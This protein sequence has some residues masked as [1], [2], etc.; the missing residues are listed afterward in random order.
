MARKISKKEL[1]AAMPLPA[2]EKLKRTDIE[3]KIDPVPV[4]SGD[5][6]KKLR[7]DLNLG[8]GAL[9]VLLNVQPSVIKA[10]ERGAKNPDGPCCKLLSILEKKGIESL[11]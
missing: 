11:L 4:Y 7:K 8:T 2:A 5:H 3:Q 6:V 1:P 10:W 9:A